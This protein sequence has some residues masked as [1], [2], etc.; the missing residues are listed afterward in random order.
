[1]IQSVACP[2][3]VKVVVR[4]YDTDGIEAESLKQDEDGDDYLESVWE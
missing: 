4:D 3:G 2:E 1:M